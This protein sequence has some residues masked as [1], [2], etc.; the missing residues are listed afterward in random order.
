MFIKNHSSLPSFFFNPKPSVQSC[1]INPTKTTKTIHNHSFEQVGDIANLVET[2][3]G[4]NDTLMCLHECTKV[5]ALHLTVVQ[6]EIG[7]LPV[8]IVE[9]VP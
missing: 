3:L 5:I 8:H 1:S 4:Y 7:V 2:M 6:I 9:A